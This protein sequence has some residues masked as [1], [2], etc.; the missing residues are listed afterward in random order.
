MENKVE[1]LQ[2]R[3]GKLRLKSINEAESLDEAK[4]RYSS[5]NWE[6]D[7]YFLDPD[8][9]YRVSLEIETNMP[10]VTV[11]FESEIKSDKKNA[12]KDAE[13]MFIYL[14]KHMARMV[15]GTAL[16]K[17]PGAIRVKKISG[18]TD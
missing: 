12:P 13:M 14:V 7:E 2:E 9:T 17:G 4:G 5:P 6:K 1:T 11:T 3:T 15:R 16:E 10:A 8:G 18:K